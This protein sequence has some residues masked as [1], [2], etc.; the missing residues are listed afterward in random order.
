MTDRL[1]ELKKSRGPVDTDDVELGGMGED[2]GLNQRGGNNE[3]LVD[4]FSNVEKVKKNVNIVKQVIKRISEIQQ[5][6]VFATSNDKEAEL[7]AE[8][9]P[10]TE[11][12]NK[13][14]NTTKQILQNLKVETEKM[15]QN[16]DAKQSEIRI[17]ENLVSTL[18]RKF[19]D[20]MKEYQSVQTK[21]KT[22]IKKKVKRHVQIVKS[23]A[24]SEE[25]DAIIRT[26]GADKVFKEAILQGEASETIR[27]MYLLVSDK[28]QDVLALEQS[29]SEL[30]QMFVDFAL[31]VEQ[32]GELLDQIEFQVKA[33]SDYI[34]EGNTQM[35]K[36]IEIQKSI[37]KQQCCML[38][39][40][41][42]VIGIIVVVVIVMTG[43][44][45]SSSDSTS[46]PSNAPTSRRLLLLPGDGLPNM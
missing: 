31:L 39:V 10:L 44:T 18:T 17:R 16:A 32:Q 12:T 13:R 26:G 46:A 45:G 22:E 14:A 23:D 21:Y 37:R 43:G 20:V 2:D 8:L 36:A 4:F 38:V 34:D 25:I 19:I 30:N 29:I 1:R 24:S 6:V 42:V 28:Y 5:Q 7:S 33:A 9:K 11:E 15:K 35:V 3:F 41:L 40:I 27:N